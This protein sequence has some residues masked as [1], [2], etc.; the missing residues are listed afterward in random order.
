MNEKLKNLIANIKLRQTCAIIIV[1]G[2][3]FAVVATGVSAFY[4]VNTS[5]SVNVVND[6]STG[7]NI[8]ESDAMVAVVGAEDSS[9]IGNT[10]SNNSWSGEIISLNNLQ[11]QPDREGTISQWY[12]HIGERVK[13]GQVIGKLSRPPQTPEM[14]SMLSEKSQM[15]SESRTNVEALRT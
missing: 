9:I 13:V 6:E 1:I 10:K 3:V 7:N 5:D 14:I 11:V 12:V 15:L 4:L 8:S 2:L